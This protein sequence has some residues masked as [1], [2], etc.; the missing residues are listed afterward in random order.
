[1]I[2]LKKAVNA[3]TL[4]GELIT[5]TVDTI[6]SKRAFPMYLPSVNLAHKLPTISSTHSFTPATMMSY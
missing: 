6:H 3:L 1:M 4:T 2:I 5:G